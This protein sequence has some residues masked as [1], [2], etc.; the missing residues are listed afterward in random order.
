MGAARGVAGVALV[1]LAAAAAGNE[2]PQT[3]AQG[4][5]RHAAWI[6]RKDV[7]A[8]GPT[9][10]RTGTVPRRRTGKRTSAGTR[11]EPAGL[12]QRPLLP[13]GLRPIGEAA[14][15]AGE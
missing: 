1:W 9:R 5:K 15:R 13:P 6:A 7:Q 2:R 3:P 10:R 8:K 14:P 12:K 11:N 4:G